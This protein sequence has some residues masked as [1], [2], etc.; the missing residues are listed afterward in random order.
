MAL[1]APSTAGQCFIHEALEGLLLGACIAK[2]L[3]REVQVSYSFVAGKEA[4]H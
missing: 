4:V 3:V 2:E 1:A